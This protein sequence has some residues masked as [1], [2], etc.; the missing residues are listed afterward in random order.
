MRDLPQGPEFLSCKLGK[1][2]YLSRDSQVS[3]LSTTMYFL[4][5]VLFKVIA[6]TN[7]RTSQEPDQLIKFPQ[8]SVLSKA[9]FMQGHLSPEQL[10]SLQMR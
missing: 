2:G 10:L 4:P 6:Q 5:W 7:L 8:V 9:L 1:Q 3:V